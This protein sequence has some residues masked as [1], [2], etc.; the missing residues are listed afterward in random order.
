MKRLADSLTA[1]RFVVALPMVWLALTL[2]PARSL[3]PEV[4]LTIVAWTSDWLDGPLARRS[5][6]TEQTWLGRHDL[7]ADLVVMVAQ[8]V[9]LV[10]W[11]M[12]LPAVVTVV[13]IGGWVSLSAIRGQ[14]PLAL[15]SRGLWTDRETLE[16]STAPLQV[17]TFVV[18][19]GFL[20]TVWSRHAALGRLLAGWLAVTLLLSPARSWHRF[21]SF[22]VVLRRFILREPSP[23]ASNEEAIPDPSEAASMQ[24]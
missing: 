22:F 2:P 6:F 7:E 16:V 13:L 9:V 5:G 12:V 15:V 20:I 14:G 4:W 19:G 8:A 11:G 24:S 10:S 18:Y 1:L 21:S 17:A 3:V 23:P